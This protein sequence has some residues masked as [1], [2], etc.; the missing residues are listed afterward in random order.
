M[1]VYEHGAVAGWDV[2]RPLRPSRAAGI[3]LAGFRD[4]SAVPA[5]LPVIPHPAV[6]VVVAFGD[7]SLVMGDASG[8]QQRGSLVAGL[9]PGAVRMRGENVTCVEV[10]LSPVVAHAVL[11]VRPAE[12]DRTVVALDDLWGR[13]A[14]RLREQLGDA[15]SWEDRFAMTDALL[16]RRRG[17]GP[18]AEP[19]VVRA[20]DRIVVSRGSVRVEDLAAEV[21]WSRRRLWSRFRSQIGLPPKRAATLVRFRHAAHRLTA[22]HSAA[23]VATEC[24]YA[25]QSHLHREILAFTG[26]TPATLAAD[27]GLAVDDIAWAGTAPTETG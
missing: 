4:R 13:D 24:G 6:T 3:S 9:V 12:L 22:G 11:G 15:P 20:W 19:E 7:G 26:M 27:P 2:A 16:S 17:T 8:W 18:P 10:R 25:D 14:A 1:T 23:W 5:D 21:G